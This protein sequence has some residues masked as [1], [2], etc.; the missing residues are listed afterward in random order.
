V[1]DNNNFVERVTS[2]WGFAHLLASV[3]IVGL[4][5]FYIKQ[6]SE[7]AEA[8]L[9]SIPIYNLHFDLTGFFWPTIE[10]M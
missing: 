1:K 9:S 8:L 6:V 4:S 5:E 7:I 2:A 3:P 10:Q